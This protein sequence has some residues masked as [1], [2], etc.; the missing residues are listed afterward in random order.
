MARESSRAASTSESGRIMCGSH[1]GDSSDPFDLRRFVDAQNHVY[2]CVIS[3]LRSG[4]KQTHWM[5]YVFPQIHGLGSSATT[6]RYAIKGIG[7]AQS[8]LRHPVL[9][10]RLR[11]CTE[12]VLALNRR[13][14]SE[15]FG[16]PDDLK[17]QSSMTL[18]DAVSETESVFSWV[19]DRYFQGKRDTRT[20]CLME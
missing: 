9:G 8:Y 10:V 7:E 15:I 3:E 2:E 12:I 17:L 18:F 1:V 6:R 20:L 13:S 11:E 5:W 14:I 16:N 19:L 4:R